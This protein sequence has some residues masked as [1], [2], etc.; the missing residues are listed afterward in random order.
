MRANMPFS[1]RSRKKHLHLHVAPDHFLTNKK[2]PS[3]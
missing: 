3:C 2:H 1:V